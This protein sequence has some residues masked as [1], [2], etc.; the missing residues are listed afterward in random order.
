MSDQNYVLQARQLV[1]SY[2]MGETRLSVIKNLDFQLQF[3]EQVGIVGASG[4][5]KSTLLHILAGLETVDQGELVIYQQKWSD[6]N[7][8]ERAKFRNHNIGFIFQLHHLLQEFTAIENVMLPC[9]IGGDSKAEALTKAKAMLDRVG[10]GQR[11][12]HYP[13]QLSGGELQRVSIARALVQKPQLLFAD[14]P[15]GSLDSKTS[16]VIQDLLFE[17]QSDLKMAMVVVT[18]D[19]Q[20]A[21]RFARC[22]RIS[23]G[24]WVN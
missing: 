19:L 13:S 16:V 18:H 15:T 3:Q 14:E 17:L 5:G 9:R 10:L 6:F 2:P 23:D 1:K 11:A 22:L 8:Q 20:F 7:D 4:S 21:S 12:Q 24:S